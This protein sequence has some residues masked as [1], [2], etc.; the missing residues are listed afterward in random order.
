MLVCLKQ[1]VV[2]IDEVIIGETTLEPGSPALDQAS[3][4]QMAEDKFAQLRGRAV[5]RVAFFPRGPNTSVINFVSPD[6][7]AK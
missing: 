3:A 4:K 5:R 1:L 2:Q 7:A 6:A